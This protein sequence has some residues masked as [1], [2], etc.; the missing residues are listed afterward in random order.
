MTL[1]IAQEKTISQGQNYKEHYCVF[2]NVK[3]KQQPRG[4]E[5]GVLINRFKK[6]GV[7]SRRSIDFILNKLGN[8]HAVIPSN[9]TIET[10]AGTPPAFTTPANDLKIV[11]QSASFFALDVDDD[12]EI[13]DP[14]S[15]L[16]SL[17]DKAVGLFY[18]FSHGIK[19]N[20]YRL[21]FQFDKPIHDEGKLKII[22]ELLAEDLRKQGIPTDQGQGKNTTLAIRPGIRG[23]VVNNYEVCLNSAEWIERANIEK[24]N[25]AER[26]K[27]N[28]DYEMQNKITFEGLREAAQAI[29]YIASGSGQHEEWTRLSMAIKHH[30]EAGELSDQEGFELFTI[31][32]GPETSEKS[33]N[34]FKP[35]GAV[36]IRSFIHK[37]KESGYRIKNSYLYAT[38]AEESSIQ[39]ETIKVS[40]HIPTE[41]AKELLQRHQRLLVDSPTGSGKTRSFITAFKELADARKPHFYIFAAPTRALTEQ[42]AAEYEIPAVTGKQEH[43]FKQ[44][45]SKARG[46]SRVF[47][48]TYDMASNLADFLTYG[49][50]PKQFT[51]VWDEAH[52]ATT[53]YDKNYRRE[54][55]RNLR[56]A[57]QK[58]VSFVALSG[59]P[60]DI[61][62]DDFDKTIKINSG[63]EASPCQEFGVYTYEKEKEADAALV[64]LIETWTKKRR[65]LVFIQSKERIEQLYHLLN[66]R[67]IKTSKVTSDDKRSATYRELI[68]KQT[69]ADDVKVL[70][71]TS[72]ISDGINIKNSLEWECIAVSDKRSPL[73]NVST[74]KQISNRFRA[75]YRRFS[76]FMMEPKHQEDKLFH[77]NSAYAYNKRVTDRFIESINS[78]FSGADINLFRS[79]V[80]ENKYGIELSDKGV[81]AD[82]L[83]LRYMA[84][85]SKERYY[86]GHRIAFIRALENI[87][88]KKHALLN[89][90]EEIRNKRLEIP[91]IA[92]ELNAAQEEAKQHKD[93]KRSA[94]EHIFIPSIHQAFRTGDEEK[95]K[96]FK[97]Q[98]SPSHYACLNR[99][100]PIAPFAVCQKVVSA[101]RKDAD[102]HRFYSR[103]ESLTDVAYFTAINRMTPTKKVFLAIKEIDE[104]I[105][106]AELK[107]RLEQLARKAK[108]SKGDVLKV[109]KMFMQT[110]RKGSKGTRQAKMDAVTID[111]VA[112][113]FGLTPEEVKLCLKN[114][115]Q[116][117]KPAVQIAARNYYSL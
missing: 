7:A 23:A 116:L 27:K 75:S 108:V 85:Q 8:G 11:F 15:V 41:V 14:L 54:A 18:T 35:S 61:L 79:S 47:V 25:R 48:S 16:K 102:T 93:R 72:V 100:S 78:E 22:M 10:T 83:H 86:A 103:L 81:A 20:R 77:I 57:S 2:D 112:E 1:P 32:S 53:D 37:A 12:K 36:T 38:S 24:L 71:A 9:V 29:G 59:T 50:K 89:I 97:R 30:T 111:S 39:S 6:K 44:I 104:F 117:Q 68:E 91:E 34:G 110:S 65:L 69:V 107:E 90:S 88:H 40:E 66:K 21:L 67:G 73:F 99:L 80:I 5:M 46:G 56:E 49:D 17:S 82:P 33:W 52:K 60:E 84:S 31:I 3:L 113:E 42:I 55:I 114:Y 95:L 64:H 74:L 62:Q 106:A 63:R 92:E 109:K 45:A 51:L 4:A 115:V 87:L 26:M 19:G 13:T 94:I 98:A 76:L 96:E 70:L 105:P 28:F 43:L 58:A 101:I